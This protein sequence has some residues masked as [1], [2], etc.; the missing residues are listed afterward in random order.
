MKSVENG[1]DQEST[2]QLLGLH[3]TARRLSLSYWTV[4]DLV[5]NAEIPS[6]RIGRRVLIDK[7]DLNRF[8]GEHR[9]GG[10]GKGGE[11]NACMLTLKTAGE[12]VS[13][14]YWYIRELVLSGEIPHVKAGKKYLVDRS[15]LDAWIE[16]NKRLKG[17]EIKKPPLSGRC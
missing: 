1:R 14:S 17:E 3:E 7:D 10:E 9:E 16:R 4:R 12:Y 2:V 5:S 8:V 11:I 15:D 6:V 13:M